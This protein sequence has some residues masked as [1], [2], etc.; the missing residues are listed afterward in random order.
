MISAS[1][2]RDW[3]ELGTLDPLWAVATDPSRKFRRWV[4]QEFFQ[5]GQ[6]VVDEVL[7]RARRLGYPAVYGSALDFGCGVGRL[8]RALATRFERCEGVD[9]ATSMVATAE[10]L[11][12]DRPNCRFSLN[13]GVDLRRFGDRSFDLVI[14]IIVLQHLP[15][16]ADMESYV[17]E[18][19][20]VLRPGGLLV[21]QVPSRLPIAARA[22]LPMRL[23]HALRALALPADLVYGRLGIAPM[24]MNALSDAQLERALRHAS[25]RVVDVVP[26]AH[27]PSAFR[28]R[29][30]YVT[31]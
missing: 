29:T 17:H 30:L 27:A 10:R 18:F 5:T 20:R 28:S 31:R 11:N 13:T 26:D 16:T 4:D 1:H 2:R 14:S 7:E 24:R 8:T 22:Q 25:A 19:V 6:H 21:F 9:I 23:Y 3:E 12:S 15:R